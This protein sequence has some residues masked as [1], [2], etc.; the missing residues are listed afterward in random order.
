VRKGG[1][2]WSTGTAAA[3]G[4]RG[5]SGRDKGDAAAARRREPAETPEGCSAAR[6][7]CQRT[8]W[9]RGTA[10]AGTAAPSPDVPPGA[11]RC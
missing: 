10:G 11:S 2:R 7:G 3:K 1:G 5:G 8:P 6:P 4:A 9:A